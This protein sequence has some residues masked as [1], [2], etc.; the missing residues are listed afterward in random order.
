[1]RK[2]F[3]GFILILLLGGISQAQDIGLSFFYMPD[4]PKVDEAIS[5]GV[6]FEMIWIKKDVVSIGADWGV[7]KTKKQVSN[8]IGWSI[9]F[10][11]DKLT[12]PIGFDFINDKFYV[13][14]GARF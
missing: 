8:I 13:G 12:F 3:I 6:T 11:L 2:L 14:L 9:R 5:F 7:F 4:N 10:H 1:M